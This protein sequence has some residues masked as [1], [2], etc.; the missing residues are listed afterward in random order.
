MGKIRGT[1]LDKALDSSFVFVGKLGKLDADFVLADMGK[2]LSPD[3]LADGQ[4]CFMQRRERKFDLEHG[5]SGK[6]ILGP[7][8]KAACADVPKGGILR[9][10]LFL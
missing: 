10:P 4:E 1:G 9:D 6:E 3:H 7:K 8:T 2:F 5:V